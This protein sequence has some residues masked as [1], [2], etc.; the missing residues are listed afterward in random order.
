MAFLRENMDREYLRSL[1]YEE[2][3]VL[4]AEIRE[5]ILNTTATNGGHLAA[6]L[7]VVELTVALFRVLD[8]PADKLLWDVGH[9]CY[10]HKI[11]SGRMKDMQSLRKSGGISGFPRQWESAYD[12]TNG[13][14]SSTA[15]GLALG[16]AAARDLAGENYKVC[17]VVGD[18]AMTGGPVYECMNNAG[19][20]KGGFLMILN[21]NKMSISENVGSLA[22][23]LDK[24]RMSRGYSTRKRKLKGFLNK[25]EK[26]KGVLNALGTF[27]DRV[28]YFI[29]PQIHYFE[30]MGFACLGPVDGHNIRA[31]EKM[32]AKGLELGEPVL[33][34]VHTKK[35]KGV[36][37]AE[38]NPEKYHGIG[39][40]D[41]K[42]GVSLDH[43]HGYSEVVAETLENLA[44]AH[45]NVAVICP[46]TPVGCGLLNF[47]EKHPE[48][49][50]DTG[51][52]ESHAVTFASGMALSGMIPVVCM[53]SAFLPRAYDMLA[54]EAVLNG[55]HVVFCMDRSGLVGGDGE[56]HQGIYDLAFLLSVPHLAV[57]S[58]ASFEE[59]RQM[60]R[61]A[62]EE[63]T[64]T[65]VIRFPKGRDSGLSI[66]AFSFGKAHV[67][68]RGHNITLVAEGTMASLALEVAAALG[69]NWGLS[70]EVIHLGTLKP[71]DRETVEASLK[72][73]GFLVTLENHAQI[74][75]VGQMIASDLSSL[76]KSLCIGYPDEWIPH[77]S[78][79]ELNEAYRMTAQAL[80]EK[81]Q[82][83]YEGRKNG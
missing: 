57:L 77:G 33:L 19:A 23:V 20:T 4:C 32:I 26:G 59:L 62:V 30:E 75:G 66:P 58:P 25:T 36:S 56:T 68:M 69:E 10:T 35:G 21:D 15:A 22:R 76:G 12:L 6:N 34:H 65:I 31:L 79:K 18:G 14:H 61:Y 9:Q 1:S 51:I 29:R 40:F 71:Y 42:T 13:G 80:S 47:R 17:C 54:Y 16:M 81:I 28:K 60:L 37:F 45:E 3:D 64:G 74:G 63:H 27:K 70:A 5:M 67:L 41:A 39:A 7:G 8:L 44:E 48:R 78:E 50:F 46:S 43:S 2:L 73:T 11:L 24:V 53:Y 72:K 52:A 49:F 38:T 55:A 83:A 82:K